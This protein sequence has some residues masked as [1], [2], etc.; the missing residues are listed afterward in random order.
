VPQS[1]LIITLY[2]SAAR[3]TKKVHP[4]PNWNSM[5]GK[6]AFQSC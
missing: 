3:V 6:T 1:T 4:L 5:L 2:M